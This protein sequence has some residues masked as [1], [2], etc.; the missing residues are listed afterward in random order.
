MNGL[1]I[2]QVCYVI[3]LLFVCLRVIYDTQNTTKTLAYLLLVVFVPIVGMVIY[4]SF[5][6][7]YRKRKMYD[8]KLVINEED[9]ND[10]KNVT[11]N[12]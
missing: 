3:L 10:S 1:L 6:V 8:K 12:I 11:Y 7:N 9:N 2:L 5:G 4:F